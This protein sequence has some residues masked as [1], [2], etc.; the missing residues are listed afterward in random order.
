MADTCTEDSFH[1]CRVNYLLVG[2]DNLD[3]LVVNLPPEQ[4]L[5]LAA[6][7]DRVEEHQLHTKLPQPK[8]H[9]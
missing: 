3:D 5:S 7:V 9:T 4:L 8:K 2:L 6:I 1:S